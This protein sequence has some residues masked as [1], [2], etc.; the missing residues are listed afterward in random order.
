[1]R[2]RF[3][4]G[5]VL[6]VVTAL[7]WFVLGRE[8]GTAGHAREPTTAHEQT[9]GA[10]RKTPE[11]PQPLAPTRF[12]PR[13]PTR[14]ATLDADAGTLVHLRLRGEVVRGDAGVEGDVVLEHLVATTDSNGVFDLEVDAVLGEFVI[15]F[16]QRGDLRSPWFSFKR[17]APPEWLRL[18]LQEPVTITGTA[19]DRETLAPVPDVV[20]TCTSCG[21]EQ[22]TT[23]AKGRFTFPNAP[24]GSGR[25]VVLHAVGA[26]AIGHGEY[27][28]T[29]GVPLEVTMLMA[30]STPIAGRVIDRAGH[31]VEGVSVSVS[32][33]GKVVL[34][35][36]SGL[37]G[38][39]AIDPFK[40]GTF[41]IDANADD[42]Q[43]SLS[44]LVVSP[45]SGLT[46]VL[47][48]GAS[49][50]ARVVD[51]HGTAV[52]GATVES[53]Q[54]TSTRSC[55]TAADG[56]CTLTGLKLGAMMVK[57]T[58]GLVTTGRETVTVAASGTTVTLE[59]APRRAVRGQVLSAPQ[60]P[61][62]GAKVSVAGEAPVV[63]TDERGHFVLENLPAGPVELSA[64]SVDAVLGADVTVDEKVEQVVIT[65]QPNSR[66]VSGRVVDAHGVPRSHFAVEDE[67]VMHGAG[68]FS[69]RV[70]HAETR[71]T[72]RCERC[73]DTVVEVPEGTSD[74]DV[75]TVTVAD[76]TTTEV[77]VLGPNGQPIA[78]AHLWSISSPPDR[79]KVWRRMGTE[80]DAQTDAR[81]RAVFDASGFCLEVAVAPY[82]PTVA[83]PCPLNTET[84]P[85]VV[86]QLT[87][88][89][90]VEV[91]VRQNGAREPVLVADD[92]E[93]LK[94]VTG[95]DGRCTLG[96][97]VPGPHVIAIAGTGFVLETKE[98][99]VREGQTEKVV[100]G[101]TSEARLEVHVTTG[102]GLR[103]VAA[104]PGDVA[105]LPPR[106]TGDIKAGMTDAQ[107]VVQFTG[108]RAGRWTLFVAE[109][110]DVVLG[111]VRVD[112]APGQSA[113]V[114]VP[115]SP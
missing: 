12:R 83:L 33:K 100:F 5:G 63:T 27:Q 77:L 14:P 35:E 112:L 94:E 85:N 102:T 66:R 47:G 41:I 111:R 36:R 113:V 54:V 22:A 105:T 60:T 9:F 115:R 26:A 96:P 52:V 68:A 87:R 44:R 56:T 103:L 55:T 3:I 71:L 81:G 59:L 51:E 84:T 110:G 2:A 46:L 11:P 53:T 37:D 38:A 43:A 108:L 73:V 106:M 57:A 13:D 109:K 58:V 70:P 93:G 6:V 82:L 16:A 114:E 89:G 42:G 23:D 30:R 99:L 88:G 49:A 76:T 45:S 31:G 90:Y 91:E 40:E 107:G 97:L 15:V 50:Q 62:A 61:A 101:E 1:M 104:L 95:L 32:R 34:R 25:T 72:V 74:V 86:V 20:V 29:P 7:A 28:A 98:V 19:V 8:R 4:V 75:G 92:T 39:F 65:L 67:Q 10:F 79:K 69:L 48:E 21:R 17:A 64:T 78:G 18:S 24:I 80:P